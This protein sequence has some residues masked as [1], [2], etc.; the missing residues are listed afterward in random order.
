MAFSKC[1]HASGHRRPVSPHTQAVPGGSTPR[2][3]DACREP[4][5]PSDSQVWNWAQSVT[6]GGY[7]P[8]ASAFLR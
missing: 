7:G 2:S 3:A 5:R 8:S 4:D 1:T 6:L